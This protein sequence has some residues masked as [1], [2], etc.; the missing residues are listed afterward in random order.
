MYIGIS[1]FREA[2]CK[3]LEL[4]VQ[5]VTESIKSQKE[6]YEEEHGGLVGFPIPM[7]VLPVPEVSRGGNSVIYGYTSSVMKYQSLAELY[8]KL[9]A[10]PGAYKNED[11]IAHDGTYH[12]LAATVH[13]NLKTWPTCTQIPHCSRPTG[14]HIPNIVIHMPIRSSPPD[15][16]GP[17]SMPIIFCGN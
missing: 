13:N 5:T 4:L 6:D 1:T 16:H 14:K 8:S 11:A 9:H 10:P 17:M 2:F 12:T 3:Y 7:D 15:H